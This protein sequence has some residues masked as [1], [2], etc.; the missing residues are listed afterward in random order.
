MDIVLRLILLSS[1]AGLVSYD[2]VV[3]DFIS[4]Y[5]DCWVVVWRPSLVSFHL[6][7]LDNNGLEGFGGVYICVHLQ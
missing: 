2:L 6:T 7:Y 3:F 4:V 1:A 5:W